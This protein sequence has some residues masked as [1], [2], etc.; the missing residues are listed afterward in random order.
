M[1]LVDVFKMV[2]AGAGAYGFCT[3][4]MKLGQRVINIGHRGVQIPSNPL[5]SWIFT[6]P[7]TPY[8]LIKFSILPFPQIHSALYFYKYVSITIQIFFAN[9]SA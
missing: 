4:P 3:V 1:A 9:S 6:V 2:S 7:L 5:F 8:F